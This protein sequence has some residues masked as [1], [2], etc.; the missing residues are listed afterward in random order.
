MKKRLR[1]LVLFLCVSLLAFGFSVFHVKRAP[2]EVFSISAGGMEARLENLAYDTKMLTGDIV[3]VLSPE[4]AE[5][6]RGK[7]LRVMDLLEDR[8]SPSLKIGQ[9][10]HHL[11]FPKKEVV[12][13]EGLTLTLSFEKRLWTGEFDPAQ[14]LFIVLNEFDQPFRFWL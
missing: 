2:E 4:R 1:V 9:S 5:E 13:E 6:Y 11:F 8:F 10:V 14:P 7:D 12:T 3:V